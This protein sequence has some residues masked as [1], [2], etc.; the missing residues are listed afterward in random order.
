MPIIN[1]PI[2]ASNLLHISP[3]IKK[4]KLMTHPLHD[5][6]SLLIIKM[7]TRIQNPPVASFRAQTHTHAHTSGGMTIPSS[8]ENK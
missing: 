4:L 2:V 7:Q 8:G 6:V 1:F 3:L 5:P